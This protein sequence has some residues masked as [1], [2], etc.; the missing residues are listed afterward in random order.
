MDCKRPLPSA[1]SSFECTE[2]LRSHQSRGSIPFTSLSSH[3][4]SLS[5]K[6]GIE[7]SN[8]PPPTFRLALLACTG[9]FRPQ[10]CTY[11][12]DL[13]WKGRTRLRGILRVKRL[14]KDSSARRRSLAVGLMKDALSRDVWGALAPPPGGLV[15]STAYASMGR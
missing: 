14:G 11:E 6:P 13:K 10:D 1:V 8:P 9:R 3:H 2:G 7:S 15:I 4:E 5:M 12:N